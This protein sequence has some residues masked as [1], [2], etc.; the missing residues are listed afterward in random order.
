MKTTF[1]GDRLHGGAKNQV[2][3]KHFNRSTFNLNKIIRTSAAV[4]T[5]IPIYTKT[6]LPGG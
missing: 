5:L 6:M 1:G 3:T 4:G 2:V